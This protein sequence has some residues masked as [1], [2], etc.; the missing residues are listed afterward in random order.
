MSITQS[1][2]DQ[3]Q[4]LRASFNDVL[5]G[6][7][8]GAWLTQKSG[9]RLTFAY[10][11]TVTVTVTFKESDTTTLG[12]YTLTY[13]DATQLLMDNVLWTAGS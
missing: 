5:G 13:T 8:V 3:A 4:V 11:D 6:I 1:Q 7:T 10:P 12:H 2:L 9:R